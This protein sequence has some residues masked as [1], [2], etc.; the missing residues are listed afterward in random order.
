MSRTI[1][2]LIFLSYFSNIY[3]TVSSERDSLLHQ[4]DIMIGKRQYYMDRKE[5]TI[6]SLRQQTFQ[7]NISDE[8]LYELYD[9]IIQEYSTYR[10][11][12]ALQYA[13]KNKEIAIKSNK[14]ELRDKADLRTITLLATTGLIKE[15][16]DMFEQLKLPLADSTMMTDYYTTGEWI[17]YT[18]RNYTEDKIYA[19]I[20]EK[21]ERQYLDSIY[22]WLPKNTIQKEYH[23]GYIALRDRNL[24]EAERILLNVFNSLNNDNRL[25]AIVTNN[26]ATL[27]RLKEK[28]DLYEKFLILASISDQVCALKENAAMQSLALY[29]YENKPDDID[30]SYRYIKCALDDAQFYNNRFRTI[31]IAQKLPVIISAYHSKS[32]IEN[33]R[34]KTTIVII[35]ILS[36]MMVFAIFYIYKQ[37]KLLRTS[38]RKLYN[39]NEQLKEANRTKEE[40]VGLF[41]DLCSSYLDKVNQYREMV[42]RKIAAKQID[43]LMATLSSNKLQQNE[44]NEF[45]HNFDT[46]FLTLYPNFIDEFNKLLDEEGQ[47]KLKKNELLNTELRIFA[48]IRLGISDS[49]KIANF[50]RYSVQTIYNYRTKIKNHSVVDRNDFEKYVQKINAFV[51]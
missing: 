30:R 36:L 47:I 42:K 51:R 31:Q 16:I 29:L 12:S 28:W 11:D 21:T 38:R 3:P 1:S 9:N 43:N 33:F 22:M 4:L 5:R 25:Y 2:L 7:A 49:S 14:K 50:L 19:P 8:R 34:L 32:E 27:Y 13:I 23:K 44:F 48:L 6:D 20:Y 24:D 26:L 17:Y 46:A 35:S 15:A 40:Y 39:L 10:Y 45:L 18:A 37:V 41:M